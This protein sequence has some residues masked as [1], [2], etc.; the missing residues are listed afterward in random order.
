MLPHPAT[1]AAVPALAAIT[2]LALAPLALAVGPDRPAAAVETVQAQGLGVEE[3]A[4]PQQLSEPVTDYIGILDASERAD[5]EESIREYRVEGQKNIFVVYLSSFGG[6]TPQDWTEASVAANGGGNTAVIAIAVDD[7]QFGIQVGAQWT[8]QELDDMYEAAYA[9]LAVDDWA[10][11][12]EAAVDAAATSGQISGESLAWLGGGAAAAVAAGGGIWAYSRRKRKNDETALLEDSR[13][14]DP[15]DTNRLMSLP[16]Q[17][18]AQLAEEELISTDESIR[19][20]RE[21]LDLAVAEFGPERTR[22]FTRAMNHSTTTLQRAFRL[23]QQINDSVPES[24]AE[25]RSMLVEIVSSCGQADDALDAEAENFADMRNLLVNAN[26][27]LRE[28]TQRTIDLRA[29]LPRA[30]EQI[31]ALKSRYST[32]VL[33]SVDD[34]VEMAETSLNEAEKSLATGR[35]LADRPAGEQGGLV[36]AIRDA[37]HATEVTERLLVAVEHAEQNIHIAKNNLGDLIS[38]VEEEIAEATQLKRQGTSQG[39]PADWQALDEVVEKAAAALESA[40]QT[41][42][43]DPLGAYTALTD[44]DADL[45]EQLDRVRETTATQARQLQLL[46]QQLNSAAGL[47]QAAEDLISSRGRV[48]KAQAR[49]YLADAQRLHAHAMHERTADTRGAIN[50]ARQAADAAQ[51]AS[52]QAQSDV[53][54]YRRHQNFN[55]PRGR[56]GGGTGSFIAGMVINQMLSGGGG[57]GGFGGGFGGGGGGFRGGGFGGGGGGGFRGGSF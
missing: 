37:E 22:S 5:I 10:G 44:I 11:A 8:D 24:E 26:A 23:Q 49:T 3:T 9:R 54:D 48:I 57:R 17:T 21:E 13:T 51:R 31:T 40:R 53:D 35:E 12:S 39:A 45:D 1:L 43:S 15:T 34:N 27:K 6:V 50:L 41:A 4:A 7:R 56:G 18:L 14:I 52:R 32:E 42:A 20:G 28:L 2:A 55:Q 47:I 36:E 19:R 33:S 46:D 25:R 29:R 38:E 30:G 16:L